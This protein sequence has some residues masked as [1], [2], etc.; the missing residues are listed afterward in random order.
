MS[1]IGHSVA[2]IILLGDSLSIIFP[3]PEWTFKLIGF[4]V[5]VLTDERRNK[6]DS[7]PSASSR[8]SFYHY[9]IFRWHLS[10][11]K[12]SYQRSQCNGHVLSG[13]QHHLRYHVVHHCPRR[14]SCLAFPAGQPATSHADEC[15]A[16]LGR[17]PHFVWSYYERSE[18]SYVCMVAEG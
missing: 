12:P 14:R 1:D 5:Y 4:A 11:G 18:Q 13:P 17:S 7:R 10:L 15:G 2:L 9:G 16:S 8:P 6:T 3:W